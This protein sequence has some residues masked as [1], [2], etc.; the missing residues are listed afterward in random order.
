MTTLKHQLATYERALD[1][2]VKLTQRY[3]DKI[4]ALEKELAQ[5]QHKMAIIGDIIKL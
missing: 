5:L 4:L 1:A 2:Q 3:A